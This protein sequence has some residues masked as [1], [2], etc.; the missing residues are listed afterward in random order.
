MRALLLGLMGA[1]FLMAVGCGATTGTTT[2]SGTSAGTGTTGTSGSTTSGS[3]GGS[4]T[5]TTTGTTTTGGLT[6]GQPCSANDSC[7]SGVCGVNGVGRCCSSACN[8]SDATCGAT[9]CDQTGT[10]LYANMGNA[11][12]NDSCSF[13]LVTH[14]SCS[15]SGDCAADT[16]VPCPNNFVCMDAA[17]CKTSCDVSADC[18]AGY[19]C[20]TGTHQCLVQ[21]VTGPCTSNAV[22]TSGICG[23][24]GTGNCC[25][26]TCSTT[27]PI[28]GASG[29]DAT[30]GACLYA[31][32]MTCGTGGETC[33]GSTLTSHICDDT[34][35][36]G[37]N[38]AACADHFA[39]NATGDG[40]L[41]KCAVL[42]DCASGYYCS[43]GACL[44][45]RATGLCSSDDACTTGLCGV[46]GTGHFCCAAACSTTDPICGATDC[47]P[48]TGACAFPGTTT[49]CGPTG[50]CSGT[51][52]TGP[53]V[54]D[55]MG[56]C[57]PPVV[58]DCTP[59]ACGATACNTTCTDSSSCAGNGDFCDTTPPPLSDGGAG[60]PAC[61]PALV[62][63][64]SLL[65]D[66]KTGADNVCCGIG[67]NGACLTLTK[68]MALIDEAQATYVTIEATVNSTGGDW[69]P[70][71]EVYPIN[72][73]YG[74]EV[75]GPGV[76]FADLNDA[77]LPVGIFAIAAYPN[78]TLHTASIVGNAKNNVN[79]GMDSTNNQTAD[80][81]AIYVDNGQTLYIANAT[82]NGSLNNNVPAIYAVQG[83]TLWLGTDQIGLNTGTVQIGNSMGNA[84]TDGTV[85]IECQTDIISLGCTV[86]DATLPNGQS[87][88]I[89]QG[90]E[91]TDIAA[92]D[93]ASV[94]LT[95][96]PVIGIAP[97]KLGYGTCPVLPKTEGS[98][99]Q[100]GG[101]AAV[102]VAG[103]ASV[104]F[105]NGTV[106]CIGGPG[107]WLQQ[108]YYMIAGT[109]TVT[110][111]NTLIQNTDGPG[112]YATAGSVTVTKSSIQFNVV[113]VEQDSDGTNVGS[114]D[115][116]GGGNAVICSSSS[117]S[118][119][120]ISNEGVDVYN[121]TDAGLKA[122]NVA[123]DTSAPD[124]FSCNGLTGAATCTCEISS[125]SANAPFDDM[126]AVQL[127]VS[128][129][130]I[131]QT[132]ASQSPLSLDAGCK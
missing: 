37:L 92:L 83:S 11:C 3:T 67:S 75:N 97:S 123:W 85:G 15:A 86:N 21:S 109:P 128:S 20:D 106:Q 65:V 32:G 59:Y 24:N 38:P 44:P 130:S 118:S 64:G 117:E 111:D 51:T 54:C 53:T 66:G 45:Q 60:S 95:S 29:C 81:T 23:L 61:C 99:A 94:T 82:V 127:S 80:R 90:Q 98:G 115:L 114:I 42:A 91:I 17:T 72:L 78:D 119:V 104:T 55:G 105:K 6:P 50:S 28:C 1:G 113:G 18:A 126:D 108:S 30:T 35:A 107:F 58:S 41:T 77:N 43:S 7:V 70:A 31:V 103:Q 131:T 4:T 74:V 49:S 19:Y 101:F 96:N 68:A 69:A 93:F 47:N 122:D 13:G 87:S 89:I 9:S 5:G 14:H 36:C 132:G 57:P 25:A 2:T 26:T 48:T 129:G 16:P 12:G 84:A 121:T 22:C 120:T 116:S 73:G 112:I 88:V 34:G 8:T 125:C 63:G 124:Y 76:Y 56:S 46:N 71:T 79:V 102:F 10:C 110:I 33:T 62:D 100:K 27:D 39:C 52:Q 40:C